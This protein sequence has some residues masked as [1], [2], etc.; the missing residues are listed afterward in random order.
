MRYFLTGSAL[1]LALVAVVPVFAQYGGTSDIISPGGDPHFPAGI[2][3]PGGDPRTPAGIISPGGTQ[4]GNRGI[5]DPTFTQ[6]TQGGNRGI[7]DPTFKPGMTSGQRGQTNGN[8]RM[9]NQP[10]TQGMQDTN[11]FMQDTRKFMQDSTNPEGM[12]DSRKQMGNQGMMNNNQ[13]N[14]MGNQRMM[15][16][17][18]AQPKLDS[19]KISKAY[20]KALAGVQK[21]NG[22][23]ATKVASAK[24]AKKVLSLAKTA[25]MNGGKLACG[26]A[27]RIPNLPVEVDMEEFDCQGYMQEQ[28]MAYR[29]LVESLS[30]AEDKTEEKEI[31]DAAIELVNETLGELS[32][33]ISDTKDGVLSAI[34]EANS[35]EDIIEEESDFQNIGF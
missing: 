3:S 23:F 4:G 20:D 35:Q 33:A 19:A 8:Q 29:E 16:Q 6:G 34:E 9:M 15:N 5:V 11:K 7:V 30:V 18:M 26:N 31:A 2:V 27:T 32:T 1:V 24:T 13:Q 22:T 28:A 25:L 12:Q 21:A 14:Q 17:K 10:G